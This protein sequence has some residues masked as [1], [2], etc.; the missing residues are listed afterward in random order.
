MEELD[1][2]FGIEMEMEISKRKKE[3]PRFFGNGARCKHVRAE[4]ALSMER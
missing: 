1:P 2:N 4:M 3:D